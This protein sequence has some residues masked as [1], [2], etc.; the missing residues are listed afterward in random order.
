V[1]AAALTLQRE[2]RASQ[3][4]VCWAKVTLV[5]QAGQESVPGG[6]L[7][8]GRS[9][10][11]PRN[12][13]ND[14]PVHA[15]EKLYLLPHAGW[16][17]GWYEYRLDGDDGIDAQFTFRLLGA[18]STDAFPVWF[19]LRVG[20]RLAWPEEIG[21][22]RRHPSNKSKSAARAASRIVDNHPVPAGIRT[23]LAAAG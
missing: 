4:E 8:L 9:P 20:A 14:V 16:L 19:R 12:Y 7:R 3:R 18:C 22:R 11:G 17:P 1:A 6:V 13:L 2:L 5:R 23:G 10:G 15:G 21:G